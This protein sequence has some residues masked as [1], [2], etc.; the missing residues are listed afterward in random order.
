M[1]TFRNVKRES[2]SLSMNLNSAFKGLL[3]RCI[4]SLVQMNRYSHALLAEELTLSRFSQLLFED[5]EVFE[6]RLL[7]PCFVPV[8]D[9]LQ[10]CRTCDEVAQG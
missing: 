6:G 2:S 7:R 1:Q 3:D 5:F 10:C 4:L 8:V 9:P